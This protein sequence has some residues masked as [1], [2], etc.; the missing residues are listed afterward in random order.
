MA[1]PSILRIGTRG[2]PLALTQARLV[3]DGLAAAHPALSETGVLEEVVIKTTG[4]RV[5]DRPLAELGGKG[6]FTKEIDEALLYG[7]IDCAVHS[8]KDVPTFLPE[9]LLLA[10]YLK[11]E[12]PRDALICRKAETLA[13]LPPGSVIGTASLRRQ[14]QILFRRPDLCVIPFRGNVETRIQ[15]L[16]AGA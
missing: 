8:L 14:A 16:E 2:S 5:L 11:R 12:D 1:S 15:K 13:G 4:D 7:R 3:R 6:L 10:C 9:G